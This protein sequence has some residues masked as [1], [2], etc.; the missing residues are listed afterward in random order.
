MPDAE[1]AH[2]QSVPPKLAKVV[3]S[4]QISYLGFLSD[5]LVECYDQVRRRSER[6]IKPVVKKQLP[7]TIAPYGR[8]DLLCIDELGYIEL[9]PR[10]TS[11]GAAKFGRRARGASPRMAA[12][13]HVIEPPMPRTPLPWGLCC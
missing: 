11:S 7:K 3:G 5:L 9:D 2:H 10:G 1:A 12:M 13:T 8:V 4:E 6:R